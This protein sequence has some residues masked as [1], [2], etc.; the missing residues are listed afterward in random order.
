VGQA[1]MVWLIGRFCRRPAPLRRRA[2]RLRL[3]TLSLGLL[4]VS[5]AAQAQAPSLEAVRDR[6]NQGVVGVM[7]GRSTGSFLY[8][9]EDLAVLLNDNAGYS[10]RVLPIIGEGS[11][12]NVEDVL[13]LRGVDLG[14]A[15][16]DVLDFMEREGVHPDIKSKV[17]YVTSLFSSE[18][19]LLARKDIRSISDLA[20]KKVNFSTPGTGSFLT[21]TNVFDALGIEVDVQSDA[22]AVALERLK[23]GEI[24]ALGFVAAPPW[25]VMQSVTPED[26][27][28]LLEVP[29]ELVTGP[30]EETAWSSDTYPQAIA[31]G[32][33]VRSIRVR[34]VM[35]AYNW[36]DN[37][38]RCAKVQRFV[39]AFRAGFPKLKEEPFQE[40]WREVNL[41]A[42]VRGL[43]R[44]NKKC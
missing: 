6:V 44:W 24:A 5:F 35:L 20:G 13:Y 11:V 29:P 1:A 22:E 27:L 30:Y 18:L 7:C 39:E 31:P 14:L 19:H 17:R 41:D 21:M 10:M 40:K 8:F 34:V 28:H 16:A 4:A 2:T 26:G 38:D 25:K 43:E 32:E 23:N 3:P 42:E 15:F 12:R 33:V 36:P 37:S 9:C